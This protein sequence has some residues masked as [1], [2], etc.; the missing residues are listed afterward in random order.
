[1]KIYRIA[2]EIPDDPYWY[3]P[4]NEDHDEKIEQYRLEYSNLKSIEEVK[5]LIPEFIKKAQIE[6]DNWDEKNIDEY[7]GGGICHLI[8]DEISSVMWEH[9][10]HNTTTTSTFEQHVYCVVKVKEGIYEIDIHHST[11][12]T[13]G[14]FSWKKIP[15]IIFEPNDI[16]IS[17]LSS[18][19]DSW[20][21]YVEED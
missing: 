7:A 20:S 21:D 6:Y 19:F 16:I 2:N 15:D 10:I 9:D 17:Q 8:A 18:D 1:M 14:G 5:A 12:E 11:Y 4:S 3:D 13:G